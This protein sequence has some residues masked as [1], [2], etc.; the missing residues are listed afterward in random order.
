M[1]YRTI[2]N[3]AKNAAIAD[4]IAAAELTMFEH[5]TKIDTYA[6]IVA[7][8]P[9][10]EWPSNIA[11]YREVGIEYLI[12]NVPASVDIIMQYRLRDETIM[13]SI[14]STLAKTK[15]QRL[16]DSLVAKLQT[17]EIDALIATA[18]QRRVA[19]AVKTGDFYAV[20]G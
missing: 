9:T 7:G 16:I 17:D 6:T 15:T 10:G 12:A 8:L 20:Q 19:G 5:D 18:V 3:A 2:D 1:T 4:A 13:R 14:L 11:N